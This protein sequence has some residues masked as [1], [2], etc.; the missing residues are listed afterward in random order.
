MDSIFF[1]DLPCAQ[2][3]IIP[4]SMQKLATSYSKLVDQDEE[5]V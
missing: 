3:K 1:N 4:H 5:T 2:V